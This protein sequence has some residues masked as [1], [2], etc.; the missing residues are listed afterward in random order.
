MKRSRMVAAAAA[1]SAS[2]LVLAGCTST[3]AIKQDYS[4]AVSTTESVGLSLVTGVIGIPNFD[5]DTLDCNWGNTTLTPIVVVNT[6]DSAQTFSI[7]INPTLAGNLNFVPEAQSQGMTANGCVISKENAGTFD[8]SVPAASGG[9]ASVTTVGYLL[10]GGGETGTNND[11]GDNN[12]AIGAGGTQWYDFWMHVNFTT[13]GFENFELNYSGTGGTDPSQN[14]QTGLFNGLNCPANSQN[15]SVT[16]DAS[17]QLTTPYV[18][19][20]A[21]AWEFTTGQPMCFGFLQP[22]SSN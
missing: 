18:K 7:T 16:F 4:A 11:G 14:L 21:N 20:N 8:V 17:T 5:D 12:V 10:G 6:Y 19:D 22:N 3:D 9:T 1:A 2:M 15:T 13:E